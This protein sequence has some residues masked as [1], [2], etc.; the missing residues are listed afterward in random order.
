MYH[1]LSALCHPTNIVL[2][3]LGDSYFIAYTGQFETFTSWSITIRFQ[4]DNIHVCYSN[5]MITVIW[6][7]FCYTKY[8]GP[9]QLPA[10]MFY[11]HIQVVRLV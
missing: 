8:Q 11:R 1:L 4:S 7:V 10:N 2:N 6:N 9:I 3:L 5:K